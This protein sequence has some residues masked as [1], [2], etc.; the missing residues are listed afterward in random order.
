MKNRRIGAA[1]TVTLFGTMAVLAAGA[2][3]PQP[4]AVVVYCSVDEEFARTV[5]NA[6]TT[7][8]GIVVRPVFDSEAGKTTGLINRIRAERDRPRADVLYSSELFNT[9]ALAEEGLL[10]P[11][12]WS[13]A[14]DIPS[15]FRDPK[16]RWVAV[17]LRGR[18]LAFDPR[19][20]SA[21]SL[22]VSWEQLAEQR[23]A[24]RLAIAN[25]LF[26]TTKGHVAAMFAM[27]GD[28]R[29]TAFLRK[30]R[31]GGAL[32]VDGNSSALRAV[33]DGRVAM[34]MTDTDDVW[35]AQRDGALIDLKYLDM[36][37][38]GTLWI[39]C[40]VALTN[41]K[42]AEDGAKRLADYLISA[43][44]ERMLAES[45]SRNIPVRGSLRESLKLTAPIAAETPYA[46]IAAA[47]DASTRAV[48]ETLLK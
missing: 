10:A 35:V 43:E 34:C 1:R 45:R 29:A 44:A 40:S 30:L 23:H 38:G 20:V 18:V 31:E 14:A 33:I 7:Q 2:C 28:E 21:E 42:L 22:P 19:R 13:S 3:A 46:R 8:T 5:L 11:H 41:R 32:I 27:W 26:G 37:N 16:G 9:I 47:M 24:S 17:G 48:R 6:F 4:D 36:G 12:D 39:P 15:Q 25:P